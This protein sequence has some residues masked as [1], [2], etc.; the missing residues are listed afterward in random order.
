MK[1]LFVF[2]AVLSAIICTFVIYA[3]AAE[4]P[5]WTQITTVDGMPD[6]SVFGDDGK[7]GATSR[8]LM[9]DGMTYPAYY[10]CKNSTSLGLSY[11]DLNSKA[12]KSYAAKDVVRLEVPVGVLSTPQAL[13]KTANGYTSLKTVVLPEGF[14]T[15]NGYT[16]YGSSTAPSVLTE[17]SLPSTLTKMGQNE[18]QLCTELEK[19]VIPEGITDIPMNFALEATSLKTLVLPK[20]LK[21]IGQTAFKLADLS[22]G[23]VIPEGCTTINNHAFKESGITSVTIPST[24]ETIGTYIFQQCNSLVTVHCKSR[25][26]GSYMF[27][28][29]DN[30]QYVTLENTVT[31]KEY[32]FC[33][34]NG[35][36]SKIDTLVLPEGLTTM[37]KYAFTRTSITELVLPSTLTTVGTDAFIGSTTLRKVV[38]LGPIMGTN[39]FNNCSALNELV[40]TEKFTTFSSNC[41]GSVSSTFTTYYSGMDYDRIKTGC[42]STPNR[43]S[44]ASFCSYEDYIAGNY[45]AKA[46]MFIYN[47][48]VC[49]VAFDGNHTKADGAEPSCTSDLTCSRCPL[50]YAEAL[51]H[52]FAVKNGATIT[53]IFY[54]SFGADGYY[55]IK[56]A[57]CTE[58]DSST[59][60]EAI[61]IPL[62]YS[63]NGKDGFATGFKINGDRLEE[64]ETLYNTTISFGIIIFNPNYLADGEFFVDGVLN[65]S[66]GS[67]QVSMSTMYSACH[68][69][70]NGFSQGNLELAF[71]GYAYADNDLDNI[72]LFQREYTSTEG[73]SVLSPMCK[74][75]TRGNQSLYTVTLNSVINPTA[76]PNK[77]ELEEFLKA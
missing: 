35:G 6:K 68:L 5:E 34:P 23:V 52:E 2:L 66:K 25:T 32:A 47:S 45:T 18:F 72:Q 30:L 8:V 29:C 57:R 33:N 55:E 49:T 77:S 4:I 43:I 21:S 74:K 26:L 44:T 71:A 50:I 39:M 9:S 27:Y 16:F 67:L 37:E 20:S 73:A 42:G 64:Y 40:L 53:N 3:S 11:T 48:N 63:T 22:D 62:G 15:L 56:C 7:A 31:I 17:I 41:L 76:M 28:D 75:V 1:R 10:I 24:I 70:V 51:G 36:I 61:F 46:C 60:A 69:S 58:L 65:T 54:E 12:G 59:V 14:T 19:L 13:L 38:V